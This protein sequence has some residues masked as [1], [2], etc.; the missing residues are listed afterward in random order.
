MQGSATHVVCKA[1]PERAGECSG[2]QEGAPLPPP[3]AGTASATAASAF[4]WLSVSACVFGG[5]G[6]VQAGQQSAP[7]MHVLVCICSNVRQFH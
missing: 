3:P 6:G 1:A 4:H 5:G 7:H 2:K